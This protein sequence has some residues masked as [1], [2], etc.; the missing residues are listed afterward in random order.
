[1]EDGRRGMENALR[2]N[3]LALIDPS[4]P[5]VSQLRIKII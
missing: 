2:A 4:T 5:V 3:L 1:M